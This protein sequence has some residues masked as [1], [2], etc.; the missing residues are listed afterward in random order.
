MRQNGNFYKQ[1]ILVTRIK[2][3]YFSSRELWRH[4]QFL[5][6]RNAS[7]VKFSSREWKNRVSSRENRVKSQFSSRD[8]E[9]RGDKFSSR[10]MSQYK[11]LVT[12]KME[13]Q[14]TPWKRWE[15]EVSWREKWKSSRHE[16]QREREGFICKNVKQNK[17][18]IRMCKGT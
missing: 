6:T 14:A 1:E 12:R 8:N 7:K 3:V 11:I 16:K 18:N 13:L 10:E 15:H 4:H 5:V 9:I 2:K 17:I